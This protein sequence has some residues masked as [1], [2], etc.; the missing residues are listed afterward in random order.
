MKLSR[1][2]WCFRALA[3]VSLCIVSAKGQSVIKITPEGLPVATFEVPY[4]AALSATG[5]IPPYSWSVSRGTL[6]PGLTL[7]ARSGAISGIPSF[8]TAP[9]SSSK[10]V[11]YAPF[12]LTFRVR[13]SSGLTADA[14]LPIPVAKPIIIETT[15]LSNGTV[16]VA[17]SFCLTATGGDLAYNG[18]FWTLADGTLPLGIILARG[19]GCPGLLR[20]TPSKAGEFPLQVRVADFHGRSAQAS[21]VLT[22]AKARHH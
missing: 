3:L 22:I 9:A 20:G 15:S 13:D 7:D 14:A 19:Q 11:T 17:Y 6:P 1:L 4:S 8:S 21:F 10:H 12:P 2:E 18:G 5:G 16:G